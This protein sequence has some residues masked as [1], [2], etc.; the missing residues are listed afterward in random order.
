VVLCYL[1]GL[2]L[3][4]AAKRLR[5]PAGTVHSRLGRARE[6]LRRGLLRRGFALSTATIAAMLAPRSARACV[7]PLLC[8]TTARAAIALAARHAAAAALA[9]EVI[10]TMLF[11]R[12]RAVA[13]AVLLI[14][15][16]TAGAG[17]L[18]PSLDAFAGSREGEPTA[19]TARTEPRPP[20]APRPAESPRPAAGRMI[21]VGRVLDPEGRPVAGVPVDVVGRSRAPRAA[22]E[23]RAEPCLALGG[24]TTGAD[25]GF[26]IEAPRT[27]SSAFLQVYALAAPAGPGLGLG[28][29]WAV[30]D[31][32]AETP[33]AEVRLKPEQVIRGKLVDVT[34]R[35]AAGVEVR[36]DL[37]FAPGHEDPVAG[38]NGWG[39]APAEGL[40][41]WPAPATTD[42]QGRFALR[43]VGRDLS[44]GLDVRDIRF[45][46]QQL[47]VK[48]DGRDGPKEV[49]LALQPAVILEG[50]ARAADTGRPIPGAVIAVRSDRRGAGWRDTRSRADGEGRFRINPFPGDSFHVSVVPPEGSPYLIRGDDVA[51]TKGAVT[52]EI[53][54]KVARGVPIR[55]K[56]TEEGTGRPVPGA[57][58]RFFPSRYHDHV[59]S[60]DEAIAMSKDDGSFQIVVPPG[61]GHL[62]VVGPTAGYVLREI[63]S[64]ELFGSTLM[65]AVR[66][67][68]HD[69]VSYEVKADE[70]A[71]PLDARLRPGRP[72]RGRL[73]GPDGQPV[74]DATI[75]SRLNVDPTGLSTLDFAP[76]HAPGG[77]FEVH[78]LD[79]ERATPVFFLDIRHGWGAAVE[80]SGRQAGEDLTIRLEPCGRATARLVGPDGQ[81]LARFDLCRWPF[82][83]LLKLVQTPGADAFS[84]NPADRAR[85]AADAVCMAHVDPE[86]YRSGL[87]TDA[88]GRVIF[89]TL[90]P[91]AP[92]RISDYSTVRVQ[93]KG[94]QVRRDFVVQP[95]E[96]VDLGDIVIEQPQVR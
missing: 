52:K 58:V 96:T 76:P 10:N 55:G 19:R 51:W 60:G 73:V 62:L 53:D 79:P 12:L 8:E 75:R 93:D 30:L 72:V 39:L 81:P 37:V 44:L 21:V 40:H 48:T 38:L 25:G 71:H 63:G 16:L 87:A 54:V 86:H 92:H 14:A 42:P 17:A 4:E 18:I 20:D 22:V 68:A 28:F 7:P 2:S 77:R 90:I 67:Y 33:A 11:H 3:A 29:G 94:A 32:D 80:L 6:S 49:L 24:G 26:R 41:A 9:Q 57:R 13:L 56:V 5:C 89:P 36:V 88:E 23:E 59:V 69:I 61:K 91:G 35:P 95:G 84:R 70:D 83:D 66:L 15:A 1:E 74:A 78:G 82:V 34:G 45:A 65:A 47:E 27:S 85:L 50:R 64:R 43:G 31:P 46:R